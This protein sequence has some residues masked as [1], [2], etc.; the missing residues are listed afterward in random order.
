MISFGKMRGYTLKYVKTMLQKT[1]AKLL[2]QES[3]NIWDSIGI[4]LILLYHKE[5]YF[6]S[7]LTFITF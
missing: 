6:C 4:F 1:T 5:Y 3:V 2:I 7:N